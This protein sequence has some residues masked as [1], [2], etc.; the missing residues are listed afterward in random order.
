MTDQDPS[1]KPT[2]K[3]DPV[4][5]IGSEGKMPTTYRWKLDREEHPL[6]LLLIREPGIRVFEVA[7]HLSVTAEVK[8]LVT[9][10][11]PEAMATVEKGEVWVDVIWRG[12]SPS[13]LRRF[14]KRSDLPNPPLAEKYW[15]ETT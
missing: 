7:Q 4:F 8:R 13:A 12:T 15:K 11:I 14:C 6:S 2:W 5:G 1:L 9:A 10:L 3:F